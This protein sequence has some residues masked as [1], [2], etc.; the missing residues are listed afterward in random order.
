MEKGASGGI[1]WTKVDVHNRTSTGNT[2]LKF[3]KLRIKPDILDYT[4][5]EVLSMRCRLWV[6]ML[7]R[8][9]NVAEEQ[10]VNKTL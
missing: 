8:N 10:V 4:I 9:N 3:K 7:Q 5:G 2:G 6:R 1:W